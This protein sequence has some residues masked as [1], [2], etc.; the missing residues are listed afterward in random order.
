MLVIFG[1]A[2]IIAARADSA[3][4]IDTMAG[5]VKSFE[6]EFPTSKINGVGSLIFLAAVTS[7][8]KKGR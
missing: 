8:I 7:A 4:C 3:V 1:Y 5:I 6:G 2:V